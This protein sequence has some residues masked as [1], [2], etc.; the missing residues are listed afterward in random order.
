MKTTLVVL[1]GEFAGQEIPIRPRFL[2]GRCRQS[3]LRPSSD[4]VSR[5]HAMI[6]MDG[7]Q[8]WIRD[9]GSTNG[10]WVNGSRLE[11]EVLLQHDDLVRI[12]PLSFRVLIQP[13]LSRSASCES[14]LAPW[15]QSPSCMPQYEQRIVVTKNGTAMKILSPQLEPKLDHEESVLAQEEEGG[16][17]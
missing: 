12:G 7:D 2:I 13:E 8:A 14:T 3:D 6:L 17:S 10:T 16:W 9:L 1:E 11:G 4:L 15:K 5:L